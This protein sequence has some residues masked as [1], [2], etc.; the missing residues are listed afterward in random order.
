MTMAPYQYGNLCRSRRYV[1]IH[2]ILICVLMYEY[3]LIWQSLSS[4]KVHDYVYFHVIARIILIWEGYNY[5]P[6]SLVM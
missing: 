1:I 2:D 6:I 3:I 5:G 4:S